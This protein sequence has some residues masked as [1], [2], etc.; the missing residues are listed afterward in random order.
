M[1][2]AGNRR[3]AR[4]VSTFFRWDAA[5]PFPLTHIIPTE[6]LSGKRRSYKID[7]LDL[8]RNVDCSDFM[9]YDLLSV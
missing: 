3:Q 8:F 4:F 1:S 2:S 7:D 5:V 6:H 9:D